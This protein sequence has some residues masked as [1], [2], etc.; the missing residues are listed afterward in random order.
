MAVLFGIQ[1]LK[2]NEEHLYCKSYVS[3]QLYMGVS[4]F[5]VLLQR[6]EALLKQFEIYLKIYEEDL[7]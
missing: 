6:S 1:V 5:L 7:P 3:V 2:G 4:S